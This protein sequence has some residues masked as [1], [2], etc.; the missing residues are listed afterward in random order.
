MG[1]YLPLTPANSSNTT[2]RVISFNDR[3]VVSG[4]HKIHRTDA[5]L[6]SWENT[7][8]V[9][10][11]Q[12]TLIVFQGDLYFAALNEFT[13]L[14]KINND[15]ASI[16]AVC[17]NVDGSLRF[18]TD[19]VASSTHL[20]GLATNYLSGFNRQI[21]RLNSNKDAWE[22]LYTFAG[23]ESYNTPNA[24]CVHQD[25]LYIG[26][27]NG[28]LVRLNLAEN[29]IETYM[30]PSWE[31]VPLVLKSYNNTIYGTVSSVDVVYKV[32][33]DWVS[34]A[35]C[36]Q[37]IFGLVACY[38]TL[39]A[40]CDQGFLYRLSQ[41]ETY[42]IQS[43]KLFA[44]I[45]SMTRLNNILYLGSVGDGVLYEYNTID[46]FFI[47]SPSAVLVATDVSAEV[48][49]ALQNQPDSQITGAVWEF[50]D[51]I[52]STDVEAY[53]TY[54]TANIYT[55]TGTFQNNYNTAT[56]T[57][58]VEVLQGYRLYYDGN[59]NTGGTTPVDSNAYGSYSSVNV[60][61]QG[62]LTK[63]GFG[64]EGWNTESDGSGSTY[65]P[66]FDSVIVYEQNITLY[67]LWL[68]GFSVTYFG[69][70][71]TSGT[72]PVDSNNYQEG[73]YAYILQQ[74]D[75]LKTDCVFLCWNTL[76]DGSGSNFYPN[77]SISMSQN[78]ELYAQWISLGPSYWDVE[79]SGVPTSVFGI[80]KTTNEMTIK[81]TSGVFE[82]WD[83][84]NTWFM[85][86]HQ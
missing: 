51:D 60:S 64:F 3:I 44:T 56:Y 21:V 5:T 43:T 79:L 30:V 35:S 20:Y 54:T 18:E 84:E 61:D 46:P 86:E 71:N 16:S 22:V 15:F 8:N 39:F 29:D 4:E 1:T 65:V 10:P 73:E 13:Q 53:H 78:I 55:V 72:S 45:Y 70:G 57:G 66:P 41:D 6:S 26:L 49:F 34:V 17:Q 68:P 58:S 83:L 24:I 37:Q 36:G 52:R 7:L 81:G 62:D 28:T 40:C 63:T 48:Y 19:L 31:G 76:P 67:A 69:N 77:D 25:R 85:N 75:L 82:N 11:N 2:I 33:D 38:D 47:P 42:F 80:G 9:T 74:G 59:G 27:N 12:S 14:W 32:Q 50:G 23:G